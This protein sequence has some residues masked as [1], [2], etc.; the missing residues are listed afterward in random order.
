MKAKGIIKRYNE[1]VHHDVTQEAWCNYCNLET[2]YDLYAR[3]MAKA[4]I[5][6]YNTSY[7]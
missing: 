7:D 5:A 1:T 4:G 6:E 3:G 2:S